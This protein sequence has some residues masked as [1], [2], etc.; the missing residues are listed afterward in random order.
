MPVRSR[1]PVIAGALLLAFSLG[2]FGIGFFADWPHP[3]AGWAPLPV[4]C[5]LAAYSC[6]QASRRTDL[7]A[8][9]RRFWKHGVLACT[10]LVGAAI[11]NA[12]DA[13]S[14]PGGTQQFSIASVCLYVAVLG[15]AVWALL[16]LPTWQRSRAER[17]RFGLD[18]GILLIT[19]G[20]L[21]WH[22]SLRKAE[23][24]T[25]QTGS[26]LP[27]LMIAI[28]AAVSMIA[29]VKVAYAGAGMLDRRS[30]HLL[31]FG[32][33]AAGAATCLTLVIADH[34]R[35]NTAFLAVPIATFCAQLAGIRQAHGDLEAVTK[36]A[37][38]RFSVVPY[39]AVAGMDAMLLFTDFTRS[40]EGRVIAGCTVAITALV[41]AR[42]ITTL[43][44]ND[45][46]LRTV[47]ASL[48]QLR[49]YQAQLAH[50]VRHDTLTEIANRANFEERVTGQLASG[51]EFLVALLD[52][53][54]FK[55][56]NDRLGHG[57][58][59]ALLKAVSRRL[60]ERLR[61]VDTVARLGGDEFTLLLPGL[62]GDEAAT[63]LRRL[64]SAVQEPLTVD[65]HEMTPRI[66]IGVTASAP[67]DT[68]GEL[69]RR[70]DVAMYAAKNDGGGRWAWFDPT[71]DRLADQDARLGADLRQALARSELR[72]LYQPIVE[73]PDGRIAGVEALLRWRHPEHGDISP[74][75]FI[76][77]AERNG[78]IIELGR[79][80][81]AQ[82]VNQAAEWQRDYGDAAP[83]RVSVNVSARQLNEPG[84]VAEVA[85]AIRDAGVDPAM[86]V[87]EVT[88]TAVLGTGAAL[89]AIRDLSEL[90]IRVALDDFGTGQ[91]SLS[92]LVDCPVH[93]LKV[94]KSFVDGVT[95]A[96][97]EAVIVDH[98]IGI[99]SGLRIL[100]VAEGVETADQ[101]ERLHQAGYRYAQ[102]F[103]FARPM[104]GDEI[105]GLLRPAGPVPV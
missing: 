5:L 96:S 72:V 14:V 93:V 17:V 30:M 25:T 39:L 103:H 22:F 41:V 102:G 11:S 101:A 21:V 94:D 48:R 50:Q 27:S 38:R 81:F 55:V 76:P 32:I 31:S 74:A 61:D 92:L 52:L 43:R 85:A 60:H 88:E 97:P 99:T 28:A 4:M 90:G 73:L 36:P 78:A 104:A 13:L 64:V 46:L 10:L 79:W 63:L 15:V 58:G 49:E 91:S 98:L 20:L 2:G 100:A 69:L 34:P 24:W 8:A 12:R 95:T 47:D 65:G 80:V 37:T 105:A 54:D 45:S 9:T 23:A 16:R 70:A 29:F 19:G 40:L 7:D 82:A 86:I 1:L 53:D 51:E 87:A 59:D 44:E 33:G 56:V 26:V 6:L 75:I 83:G 57:T 62:T 66:S 3:V 71:M 67:G 84:F 68:P 89:E 42:Q 18:T 35:L 77:L